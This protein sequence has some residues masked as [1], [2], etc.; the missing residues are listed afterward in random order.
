MKRTSMRTKRA[1]QPRLPNPK[2][3]QMRVTKQ[4]KSTASAEPRQTVQF[5]ASEHDLAVI[6]SGVAAEYKATGVKWTVSDFTRRAITMYPE[7]ARLMGEANARIAELTAERDALR[8]RLL[9]LEGGG[10]GGSGVTLIARADA[11]TGRDTGHT[12]V[13]VNDVAQATAEEAAGFDLQAG[14]QLTCDDGRHALMFDG[15]C[16]DCSAEQT[17]DNDGASA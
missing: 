4:P 9:R 6:K 11:S 10:G 14:S 16:E 17:P 12:H 8:A 13:V 3:Q 7:H 1:R 5:R 15:P 2:A